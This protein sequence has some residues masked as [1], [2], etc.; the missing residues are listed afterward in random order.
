MS[1]H[2]IVVIWVMKIFLYSSVYSC[3]LFLISSASVRFIPFLSFI[4]PIFAWI[5]P[6]V[7]LIFLKRSP[8]FPVLMS[9]SISLHCSL[10]KAFSSLL[11][12]LLNSVFRWIY[13][14]FS[15][16]PFA[17]LHFSTIYKASLDNHFAFL[18]LLDLIPWI[19]LYNCSWFRS[20]LKWRWR[21]CIQ[22][23]KTKTRSWLWLRS[24]TPY[25]K[26]QT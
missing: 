14:S 16:L 4:V 12:V 20:C 23:G 5:I 7:S 10:R 21:S 15:P 3:H 22:S 2:T 26:T 13:L 18:P 9:S 25:C 19:C 1:G 8:V 11:A 6:L 24:W 17:F